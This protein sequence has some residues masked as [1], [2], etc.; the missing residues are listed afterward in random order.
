VIPLERFG[1][2]L[3]VPGGLFHFLDSLEFQYDRGERTAKFNQRQEH[4]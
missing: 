1:H 3:L 4:G 2:G